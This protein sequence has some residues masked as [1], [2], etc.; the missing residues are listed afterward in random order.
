M[1]KI[2]ISILAF[3]FMLGIIVVL[4]ELG[5]FLAARAFGIYCHEFSIGMGPAL[6]QRQ[7][8]HTL[9][10]IRAFPLGGYCA[11]AG[12]TAEDP[13]E[14]D[15]EDGIEEGDSDLEEEYEEDWNALV[16]PEQ[17]MNNHPAW[18]QV[19]VLLAGVMMNF[20]L[21]LVLMTAAFAIRGYVSLPALPVVASVAEDSPAA[22]GGLQE[23]DR[24]VRIVA[25]DGSSVEPQILNDVTEFLVYNRGES[26][27]TVERDGQEVE[28]KMTPYQDEESGSWLL[29]FTAQANGKSINALEAIPYAWNELWYD[30]GV[31]GRSVAN[32]VQGKALD[33]LSGPVGIYK[34]TDQVVSS[35][36]LPYVVWI[37]LVSLNVGLFNLL[38]IPAL[39]GGRIV[40]LL[41]EKLFR[42]K[43]SAKT[44]QRIILTSYALVLCLLIYCTFNDVVRFF[45]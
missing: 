35:G 25:Q 28:L 33:S 21:A 11:I 41:F 4:H 20:I 3:V 32:L 24:I 27:Y 34:A 5:H 37:A 1:I 15:E 6:Y 18:Q 39:D 12:E 9:F 10:S 8:K 23:G 44:I 45:V 16:P 31:M 22:R 43:M 13:I 19:I 38:P 14:E 30:L 2:L 40:I 42:K 17:K 36:F 29:G 26:V 7:G